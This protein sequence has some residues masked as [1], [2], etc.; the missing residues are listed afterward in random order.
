MR[1]QFRL[2]LAAAVL[3]CAL[4]FA[5]AAQT[6]APGRITVTA[7]GR[8]DAV[9]DMATVS[10]GVVTRDDTAA[11]ALSANSD[12][13][14]RVLDTLTAAGIAARDLQTT[15]LSVNPDW[16]HSSGG[17]G[18]IRG[19]IAMNQ[20]TARVRDMAAL[21]PV[22]DAAVKDGANTLNGLSFALSDPAPLL[23]KARAAAV[24]EARAR[25]EVLA[26]AAGVTLGR[27]LSI[28]EGGGGGEAPYPAFR[29]EAMA[30][31]PVA[32][33]EVSTVVSVTVIWEIAP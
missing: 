28:T 16:D 33:G 24:A 3:A 27:V 20:V 4:P 22:L 10:L 29:A 32:Q 30:A 1:P 12:A 14:A 13:V 5:V 11:G 7:E 26:Q 21:G 6:P 18:R 23:Q 9:P 15:G 31:P 8:V 25:A 2:A 19:Y 17:E